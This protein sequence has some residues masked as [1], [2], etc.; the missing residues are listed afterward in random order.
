L[1]DRW[2]ARALQLAFLL[3][4]VLLAGVLLVGILLLGVLLVTEKEMVSAVSG[5]LEK[6]EKILLGSEI[7]G[8]EKV[9]LLS[10]ASLVVWYF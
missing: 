2:S 9:L 6:R 5:L 10:G 4:E 7:L 1:L 8:E 3:A